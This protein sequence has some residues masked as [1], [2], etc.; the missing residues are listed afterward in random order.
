MK[1]FVDG[2]RVKLINAQELTGIEGTIEGKAY[3]NNYIVHFDTPVNGWSA[4]S[5]S[6]S[7]IVKI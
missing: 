3:K 4:V 6:E 7:C 1:E 5:I 2:E